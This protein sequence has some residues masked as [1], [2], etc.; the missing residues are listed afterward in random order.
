M[1]ETLLEDA[2]ASLLAAHS[3]ADAIRH[4]E[5]GDTGAALWSAIEES[6]FADALVAESQ[7]GAGLGL[8]D[9]C[10]LFELC[11]HHLLP[12][13]LAQTMLARGV[14]ALHDHTAPPGAMVFAVSGTGSGVLL[15]EGSTAHWVLLGDGE[16]LQLLD[17]R[18]VPRERRAERSLDVS[19]R[20][21]PEPTW[22]CA[23]TLDMRALQ[24]LVLAAQMAG[25]MNRLLGLSLR[26]ANERSQFGRSIGK[27]QAIQH[28]LSVMAEHVAAAR[29][30]A[31]MGCETQQ[32][33]P[34]PLHCALAKARTSAAVTTVTGVA[35]AVHGAIGITEE[36]DLQL[37]TR[38]LHAWRA[39][40]GSESYWHQRIG[41]A[42]VAMPDLAL[43]DFALEQLCGV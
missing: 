7:G 5:A 1:A 26:F 2:L 15:H 24:A 30:A 14:L 13:P 20:A 3:T 11:G 37:C 34:D 17:I 10:A 18:D 25:A 33:L 36:F 6:G 9:A 35:H 40:A 38:R 23:S 29:T 21:L 28:Q 32:V 19:L 12:T 41:A 27:F 31:R 4:I 42:L 43:P 8:A 16:R 22:T 39:A